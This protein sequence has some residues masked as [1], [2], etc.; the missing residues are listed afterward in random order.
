MSASDGTR[1]PWYLLLKYP[2]LRRRIP[3]FTLLLTVSFWSDPH[4][5]IEGILTIRGENEQIHL[6]YSSELQRKDR[7]SRKM[8][9]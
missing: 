1:Q 8:E 3:L 5:Q 2:V 6:D 4:F 7:N 9:L